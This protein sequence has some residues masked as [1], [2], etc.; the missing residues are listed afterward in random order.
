MTACLPAC[1]HAY[2]WLGVGL[3][4][5]GLSP[6]VDGADP[7][8]SRAVGMR[9]AWIDGQAKRTTA[10]CLVLSPPHPTIIIIIQLPLPYTATHPTTAFLGTNA[11]VQSQPKVCCDCMVIY[12][13]AAPLLL[14]L[15]GRVYG[16]AHVL[17][18]PASALTHTH[19]HRR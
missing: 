12:G 7:N 19:G 1:L 2:L 6:S 11:R 18:T 4:Q 17:T 14:L 3:G 16:G 9:G 10:P 5:V 15:S 8:R 13:E